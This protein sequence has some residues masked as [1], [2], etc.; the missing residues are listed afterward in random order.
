MLPQAEGVTEN[1]VGDTRNTM[2]A[3]KQRRL[4]LLTLRTLA[5]ARP[6]PVDARRSSPLR[7]HHL[8]KIAATLAV[9]TLPA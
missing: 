2:K 4:P 8:G 7:N 9:E 1:H 6:D 3:T 5:A